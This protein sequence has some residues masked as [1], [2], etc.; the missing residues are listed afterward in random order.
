MQQAI[1]QTLFSSL[2]NSLAAAAVAY[3]C[4]AALRYLAGG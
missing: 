1:D 2:I 4:G 3:G